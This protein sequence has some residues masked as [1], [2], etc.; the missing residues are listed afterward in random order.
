MLLTKCNSSILAGAAS[1]VYQEELQGVEDNS[2]CL[3]S[4]EMKLAYSLKQI[5]GFP[6]V[7][8]GGKNGVTHHFLS[9]VKTTY[10]KFV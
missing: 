4:Y 3:R 5:P 9:A 8:M 2:T 1:C 6:T 10:L 7:W